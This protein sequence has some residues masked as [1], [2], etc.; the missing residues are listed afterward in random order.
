MNIDYPNNKLYEIQ[1]WYNYYTCYDNINKLDKINIQD[2]ENSTNRIINIIYNEALTLNSFKHIYLIGVSQGGTLLFNILNKLPKNIGGLF[3]IKSIYMH[4]YIKLKKNRKT[5][6]YIYSGSK[7]SI[8]TLKFQKKC[9]KNLKKYKLYHT[10]IKD[11]DHF[12]I[13]IYEQDFI[14]NSFL[15][16]LICKD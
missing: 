14:I 13:E 16:T 12:S 11:L 4:K 3:V 1:S 5:P 10:I 2:F 9:L 7:D 6:I 8:Y 15:D